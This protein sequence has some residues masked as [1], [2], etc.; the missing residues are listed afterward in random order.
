MFQL[1]AKASPSS[2]IWISGRGTRSIFGDGKFTLLERIKKTGSIKKACESLDMS[3]RK[4]WGDLKSAERGLGIKLVARVRGGNGGGRTVLTERGEKIM[5]AY[6]T[7]RNKVDSGIR[8]AFKQF[9]KVV[10]E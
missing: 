10:F 7:F 9:Y 8:I 5:E 3:Y 4:A 6:S 1:S 2:K